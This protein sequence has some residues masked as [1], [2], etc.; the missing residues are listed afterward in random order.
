MM[1]LVANRLILIGAVV[2]AVSACGSRQK[3][4]AVE[5]AQPAPKAYGAPGV[6][7]PEDLLEASTQ[8]RP[9]RNVELRRRSEARSDDPF[10]LS[11]E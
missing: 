10:D 7:V 5:G 2:L 11:P 4:T 9:E 8:A 3:L 1:M 6:P